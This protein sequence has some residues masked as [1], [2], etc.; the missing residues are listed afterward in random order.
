[1]PTVSWTPT[2][3]SELNGIVQ[4]LTEAGQSWQSVEKIAR[5]I[6]ADCQRYAQFPHL[7]A[8][9]P[10]LGDDC[11]IF[12]HKRWAV[13]YHPCPGGIEIVGVVD[14]ARD[15]PAWRRP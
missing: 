10:D 4:Y 5:E 15:Y 13:I 11:R 3:E 8:A 12:T 6:L 14:A 1:M 7:G 9:A 2:A